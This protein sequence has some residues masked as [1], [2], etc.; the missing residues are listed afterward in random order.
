M[1]SL[2]NLVREVEA[3][4][5]RRVR[6]ARAMMLTPNPRLA[7]ENWP[8]H[9]WGAADCPIVANVALSHGLVDTVWTAESSKTQR[10]DQVPSRSSMTAD[11]ER[12]DPFP[13]T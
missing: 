12:V 2:Q 6:G 5:R 3:S 4:S 13:G 10:T 11:T 1:V 7:P 8:G 9:F